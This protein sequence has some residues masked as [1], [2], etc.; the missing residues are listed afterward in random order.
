MLLILLV[1]CAVGWAVTGV[2]CFFRIRD[3]KYSNDLLG[4]AQ[5]EASER[6]MMAEHEAGRASTE[7]EYAKLALAQTL[8]RP[9]IAMIDEKLVQ[10]FAAIVASIVHP[11]NEV[12]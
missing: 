5:V 9:A 11:E 3:L 10:Q 7:A 8:Q 2:V 6:A 1:I 12:N 4:D